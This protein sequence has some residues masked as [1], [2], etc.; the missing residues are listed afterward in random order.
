MDLILG[1]DLVRGDAVSAPIVTVDPVPTDD[2][3]E[4][5]PMTFH[6]CC[7]QIH[8]QSGGEPAFVI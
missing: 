2:V 1:N 5:D 3:E 7:N 4:E 6:V 8:V